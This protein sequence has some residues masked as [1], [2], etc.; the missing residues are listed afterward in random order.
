MLWS[1]PCGLW[2]KGMLTLAIILYARLLL[3]R[4]A[5][6]HWHLRFCESQGWRRVMPDQTTRV[7]S[8]HPSTVV[9]RH[10]IGLVCQPY[11]GKIKRQWLYRDS[12]GDGHFAH[13]VRVLLW[14]KA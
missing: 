9:T 6:H 3:K 11:G 2:V 12:I 14:H 8:I 13:M 7:V 1:L 4:Q 5:Q 10:F